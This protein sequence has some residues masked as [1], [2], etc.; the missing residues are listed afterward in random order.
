MLVVPLH[1]NNIDDTIN[2]VPKCLHGELSSIMELNSLYPLLA[3]NCGVMIILNGISYIRRPLTPQYLDI[4]GINTV[5]LISLDVL[6]SAYDKDIKSFIEVIKENARLL[7]TLIPPVIETGIENAKIPFT[8]FIV[9]RYDNL[10]TYLDSFNKKKRYKLKQIISRYADDVDLREISLSD[11]CDKYES[12]ARSMIC[13][14][15]DDMEHTD[16]SNVHDQI[17][18]MLTRNPDL[19]EKA[20]GV[21]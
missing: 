9:T 6:A 14:R 8:D 7:P 12:I 13:S 18:D 16:F 5:G 2:L 3:I 15:F 20:T 11:W 17:A 1:E 21:R 10:E 19:L 4:L